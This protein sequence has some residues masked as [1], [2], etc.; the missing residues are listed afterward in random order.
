VDDTAILTAHKDHI[1]ASQR[2]QES[3]F[4][5]SHSDM[6]TKMENQNQW[7]K[8]CDFHHPQKDVSSNLEWPKDP[9]S[10]EREV[11]GTKSRS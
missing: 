1:E 3:L 7:G 9:S 2:L 5:K 11:F 8:I 10:R 6:A 4:F